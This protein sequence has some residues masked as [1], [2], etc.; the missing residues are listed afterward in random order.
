MHATDILQI[1]SQG[2]FH[3]FGW[4]R[5]SYS[6]QLHVFNCVFPGKKKRALINKFQGFFSNLSFSDS[7]PWPCFSLNLK[8]PTH[9]KCPR[10]VFLTPL[11]FSTLGFCYIIKN[12]QKGRVTLIWRYSQK[13]RSSF[14]APQL[15]SYKKLLFFI[16]VGPADLVTFISSCQGERVESVL[17]IRV[18]WKLQDKPYFPVKLP[19]SLQA[20]SF[21]QVWIWDESK[22]PATDPA[23]N[24]GGNPRLN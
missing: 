9:S 14:S 8:G 20:M 16:W 1:A 18:F 3:A 2:S 4:L 11:D 13:N 23:Q 6:L 15:L 22:N 12:Y 21:E 5:R 19:F 24:W 10:E 7:P 17:T